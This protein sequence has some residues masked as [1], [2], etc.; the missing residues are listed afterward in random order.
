MTEKA[1]KSNLPVIIGVIVLLAVVGGFFLMSGGNSSDSLESPETGS[2]VSEDVQSSSMTSAAEQEVGND[3]SETST[4]AATGKAS[5][6]KTVKIDGNISASKGVDEYGIRYHGL[7]KEKAPIVLHEFSSLT[8]GHCGAFH[9]GAFKDLMDDAKAGKVFIKITDFPL[10]R[11]ALDAS[12]LANCMAPDR[13]FKFVQLLFTTQDKWVGE[14]YLDKLSQNAKLAGMSEEQITS[15]MQNGDNE[16]QIVDNIRK[17]A[18]RYELRAT[19]TFFINGDPNWTLVGAQ[20]YSSFETAFANKP[21][22][23][24]AQ[25]EPETTPPVVEPEQEPVTEA[26]DE[27][28]DTV[29]ET[30]ADTSEEDAAPEADAEATSETDPGDESNDET[31]Q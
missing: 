23:A 14:D 26:P 7:G 21:S 15:C 2:I 10:D 30:D 5:T 20:P 24:P 3:A 28:D 11:A 16:K 31:A 9:N 22:A 6:T 18:E 19:P 4:P 27:A 17:A 25:E 1:S 12:I 29:S 13:Y 8:C